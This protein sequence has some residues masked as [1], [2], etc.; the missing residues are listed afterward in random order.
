MHIM[1]NA[2]IIVIMLQN[3]ESEIILY[4]LPQR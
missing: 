3:L 2:N 4:S 1:K